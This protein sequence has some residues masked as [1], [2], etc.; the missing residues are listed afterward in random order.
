VCPHLLAEATFWRQPS[1][2]AWGVATDREVSIGIDADAYVGFVAGAPFTNGYY[3]AG[4]GG[5]GSADFNVSINS[6]GGVN[7]A[8]TGGLSGTPASGTLN[9]GKTHVT[10]CSSSGE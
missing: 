10:V 5:V 6:N 2:G 7:A 8:V 1:T 4:E 3:F 9:I